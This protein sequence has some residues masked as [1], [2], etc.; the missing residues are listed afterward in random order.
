M[1]TKSLFKDYDEETV[2]SFKTFSDQCGKGLDE[3]LKDTLWDKLKSHLGREF[4]TVKTS[5]D[6]VN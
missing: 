6:R 2:V 5:I 4:D 3:Y 1:N